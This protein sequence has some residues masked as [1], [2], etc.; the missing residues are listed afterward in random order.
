[1]GIRNRFRGTAPV[2]TWL[3]GGSIGVRS[4]QRGS[5]TIAGA[6]TSNTATITSVNLTTSIVTYLGCTLVGAENPDHAFARVT[7]TDATT[8]TATKGAGTGGADNVV[9]NYDVVEFVSG[10]L[11][12]VQRGTI[13]CAAGTAT[14]TISAVNTAKSAIQ[15]LGFSTV[16]SGAFNTWLP[17]IELTDATTVTATATATDATVGYQVVEFY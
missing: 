12:S 15:L 8:V 4:V 9:L 16:N 3:T 7:L 5:I 2:G 13:T 17:R 14:A 6:S 11:K 1:M 10:A